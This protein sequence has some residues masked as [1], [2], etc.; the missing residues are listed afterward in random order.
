MNGKNIMRPFK[1]NNHLSI[2]NNK[3]I[4]CTTTDLIHCMKFTKH[5]LNYIVTLNSQ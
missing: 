5:G 1:P 2:L 4:C 3:N